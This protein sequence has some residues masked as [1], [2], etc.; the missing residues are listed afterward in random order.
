MATKERIIYLFIIAIL[1][2]TSIYF[3]NTDPEEIVKTKT[4]VIHDTTTIE[5]T[6]V[7]SKP[8]DTVFDTIFVEKYISSTDSAKCLESLKTVLK[9]YSE[10]VSYSDTLMNDSIAFVKVD[11]KVKFNKLQY[12]HLTYRNNKPTEVNNYEIRSRKLFV[13][14]GIYNGGIDVGMMYKTKKDLLIGVG[15]MPVESGIRFSAYI[16][17]K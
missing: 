5:V 1:A 8:L 3:L 2:I 9:E 11:S 7:I 16:P 4:E 14:G 15:Y 17:L 6:K 10:E 12:Q 13:G